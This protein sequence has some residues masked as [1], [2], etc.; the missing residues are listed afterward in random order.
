MKT[1]R[2]I[3][4]ALMAVLMCTNFSSCN[5]DTNDDT[6]NKLLGIWKQVNYLQGNY[7]RN[8]IYIQFNNDG[9][10]YY[11]SDVNTLSTKNQASW[12][13]SENSKMLRIY[14]EDGYYTYNF[15]FEFQD[16]GDWIGTENINGKEKIYIYAK[17]K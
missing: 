4:M 5:D 9:T 15:D 8:W 17:Y 13:Y 12:A 10:C 2:F 6:Q 14:T 16:N 7:S 11:S 3:G 1:F